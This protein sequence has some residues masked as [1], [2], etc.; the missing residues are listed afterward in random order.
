MKTTRI[1]VLA[2]S[3]TLL[4]AT[5]CCP[6]DVVRPDSPVGASAK[7]PVA[8]A[9]TPK[10]PTT[11]GIA[12]FSDSANTAL[13]AFFTR[14]AK[15]TGRKVAVFD[16]DGTVFGQTP[17]YLADECLF[18]HAKANP[19]RNPDIIA[20]MRK[21]S[22]VSLPYVQNRIRY[23]AGLSLTEIRDLGVSCYERD[24]KGKIYPPMKALVSRLKAAG[25]EVWVVTAS[26]E[27]LYQK[28]LSQA[29]G[30]AITRVIGVKS[31]VSGGV[32]T[33]RMVEPVPQDKGKLEAI[34]T[35][36]QVKPLLVGGNSRGDKEMIEHS[37][38]VKL[39]VNPDEHVAPD[40]TL[41]VADY[42]K[43]HGWL[44]VRIRDVPAPGFPAVSSKVFGMRLNKTRDVPAAPPA[45]P[46]AKKAP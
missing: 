29:L 46:P 10:A 34:E 31:V 14:T 11:P 8:A 21:Q 12:G 18:A 25:F 7:A 44:V 2:A 38:D 4:L 27:A 40:Q 1:T 13:N 23:M 35:F 26:P 32:T 24:Y 16:G 17:H 41:S 20:K 45:T 28:F 42:A 6:P 15:H 3:F 9:K 36:V 5:A 33:D 22:N 30:I 37:A 19:E 43:K 39:I